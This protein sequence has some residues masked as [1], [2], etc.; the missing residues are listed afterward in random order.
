[1][2]DPRTFWKCS[3]DANFLLALAADV[4]S[5]FHLCNDVAKTILIGVGVIVGIGIVFMNPRSLPVKEFKC[6]TALKAVMLLGWVLGLCFGPFDNV[7]RSSTIYWTMHSLISN[8]APMEKN[9]VVHCVALLF[10]YAAFYL[11]LY[12]ALSSELRQAEF[13]FQALILAAFLIY[14]AHIMFK[15][16]KR[17]D[18]NN[19]RIATHSAIVAVNDVNGN[20]DFVYIENFGGDL[21]EFR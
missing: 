7:I 19:R 4:G 20:I 6:L 5:D 10:A 9:L 21:V 15:W 14:A 17:D 16:Q 8:C 3:Y 1:M 18:E 13:A 2:M 12:E 11:G